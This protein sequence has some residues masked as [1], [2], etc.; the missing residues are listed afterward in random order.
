M[1]NMVITLQTSFQT[2]FWIYE[3]VSE[4]KITKFTLSFFSVDW[5]QD[6]LKKA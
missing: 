5:M 4:S 3:T 2:I 1:E 6:N